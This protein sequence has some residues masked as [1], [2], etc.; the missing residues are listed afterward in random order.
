MIFHYAL[1]A[2]GLS[3]LF[4]YGF[5]SLMSTF[6]AFLKATYSFGELKSVILTFCACIFALPLQ[7]ED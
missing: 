1:E 3:L 7:L 4:S 6:K 5:Q 2:R